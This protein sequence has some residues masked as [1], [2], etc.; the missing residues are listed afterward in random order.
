MAT[1]TI[2]TPVPRET[3]SARIGALALPQAMGYADFIRTGDPG[4]PI[5]CWGAIA[6]RF[7]QDFKSTADRKALWGVLLEEG[8]RRPLLLYLHANRDRP[9][10]MAMVL[11][12]A[13]R[14]PPA[15]QRALVSFEEVAD[16]LPAHLDKLDPAARQL[17]EAGP[18]AL[19]R[20]REQ[21]AT[22]IAQLTAFRYFVP[23]QRDPA[24][25]TAAAP[26]EPASTT[27]GTR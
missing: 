13:A 7:A 6:D 21:F 14:L 8:D 26:T 4:S 19:G 10:V 3:L 17:F 11:E 27:G 25:E 15:L 23:D 16:L 2:L 18:E 5:P 1:R 22:R 12:Q 9:E 20:E 24:N